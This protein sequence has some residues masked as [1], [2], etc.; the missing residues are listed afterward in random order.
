M[1]FNPS[2]TQVL[3][4]E[5]YESLWLYDVEA[6]E[7]RRLLGELGREI[8]IVSADW[9]PDGDILVSTFD[10]GTSVSALWSYNEQAERLTPLYTHA[11]DT[12]LGH[13][14]VIPCDYALADV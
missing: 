4:I 5:N 1:S 7:T 9:L 2:G 13:A 8:F 6:N 14:Q 10:T 3:S 12:F 11:G